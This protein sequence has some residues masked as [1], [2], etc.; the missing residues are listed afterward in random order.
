MIPFQVSLMRSLQ[1]I[2]EFVSTFLVLMDAFR[3][4][5]SHIH[6]L[7]VLSINDC[8]HH[9]TESGDKDSTV[10]AKLR[11]LAFGSLQFLANVIIGR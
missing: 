4:S 8:F 10:K 6:A 2:H 7:R 5:Y 9:S 3:Y 1:L 11:S